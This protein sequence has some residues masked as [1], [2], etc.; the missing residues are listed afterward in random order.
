[1]RTS[2]IVQTREG[3]KR[4]SFLFTESMASFRRPWLLTCDRFPLPRRWHCSREGG[5]A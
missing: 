4:E 3:A 2:F 5:G 1:M